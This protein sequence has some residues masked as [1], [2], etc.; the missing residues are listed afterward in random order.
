VRELEQKI[1][2]DSVDAASNIIYAI[3]EANVSEAKGRI[4]STYLYSHLMGEYLK[5]E[6]SGI[7][8]SV[9][10]GNVDVRIR[11]SLPKENLLSNAVELQK[12]IVEETKH[13][14]GLNV[15][16]VHLCIERVLESS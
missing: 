10:E 7:Y 14:T 3:I 16:K 13:L 1:K 12:R 15:K 9:I 2:V 5:T 11:V 4:C 8:L 6:K